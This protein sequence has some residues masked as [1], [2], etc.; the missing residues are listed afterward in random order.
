[1]DKMGKGPW[2]MTLRCKDEVGAQ[3]VELVAECS[4]EYVQ[5]TEK[6]GEMDW[7]AILKELGARGIKSLMVEGG[8][9]VINTLLQKK[10][11]HLIDT[12][13]V[14]IAPIWLGDTGVNVSPPPAQASYGA[15]A[16]A[17]RLANVKW[18]QFGQDVVMC[19]TLQQ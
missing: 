18:Q 14:T 4:G 15:P 19:G 10:Y 9:T 7:N 1:M 16:A 3:H 5:V 17:A 12:V 11:L 8:A 2:I 6:A 13:I